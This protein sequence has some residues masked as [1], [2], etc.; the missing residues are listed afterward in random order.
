MNLSFGVTV[1][2]SFNFGTASMAYWPKLNQ[3]SCSAVEKENNPSGKES[4]H[5]LTAV[6]C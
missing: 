3:F 2:Y 4:A 6:S 1:R 5:L